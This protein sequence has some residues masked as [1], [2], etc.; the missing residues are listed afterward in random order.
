MCPSHINKKNVLV[1][2]LWYKR[3]KIV[4]LKSKNLYGDITTTTNG[5]TTLCQASSHHPIVDYGILLYHLTL[6]F[7]FLTYLSSAVRTYLNFSK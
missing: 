5:K 4:F 2:S 7:L 6:N 3:I 1:D